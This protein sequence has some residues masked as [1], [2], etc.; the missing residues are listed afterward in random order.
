[1]PVT[2][3]APG[4]CGHLPQESAD[5]G[6]K[7]MLRRLVS[8]AGAMIAMTAVP[9]T[10]ATADTDFTYS[11]DEYSLTLSVTTATV[12]VPFTITV[13]GP[14]GNSSFT[15]EI[16]GIDDGAIEVAGAQTAS[17]TDGTATFAATLPQAG[18]Y[19]VTA[20][21]A[22]GQDAGTASV[23]AVAAGDDG[24][25]EGDGV[26]GVVDDG[27]STS[28]AGLLPVTGAGGAPYLLAAGALLVL[29]IAALVVARV[30]G[31]SH[32]A[33]PGDGSP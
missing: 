3:A 11:P 18:T 2:G 23:T 19:T 15:V 7:S 14:V 28:G 25:D 27:D 20:T 16:P 1:M 32:R 22:E 5:P 21:D 24:G 9:A 12:G 33:V 6:T 29:G 13:S 31:R 10:A 30:R 17:T 8:L 4:A 26:A